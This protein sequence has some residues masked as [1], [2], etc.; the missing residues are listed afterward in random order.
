MIILIN[1]RKY[2][3]IQLTKMENTSSIRSKDMRGMGMLRTWLNIFIF[4]ACGY[5]AAQDYTDHLAVQGQLPGENAVFLKRKES[6]EILFI[7]DSLKVKTKVYEDLLVLNDK[8][9]V[10][11][12]RSVY[13]SHF[14]KINGLEA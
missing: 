6:A 4:L 3:L 10:Y 13:F 9:S 7:K 14:E 11:N 2:L 12:E 8:G 5:A 1:R